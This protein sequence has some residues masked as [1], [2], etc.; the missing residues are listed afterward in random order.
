MV[1]R[2]QLHLDKA[3]VLW[4]DRRILQLASIKLPTQP[5]LALPQY[6]CVI[7]SGSL[8]EL[9]RMMHCLHGGGPSL[10]R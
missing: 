7:S 10:G 1:Q 8:D 5:P 6:V 3:S 4:L 9:Q 2:R